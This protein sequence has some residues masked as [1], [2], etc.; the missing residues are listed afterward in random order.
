MFSYIKIKIANI[1]KTKIIKYFS[2]KFTEVNFGVKNFGMV[3]VLSG[4]WGDGSNFYYKDVCYCRTCSICWHCVCSMGSINSCK[5]LKSF[6]M[7]KKISFLNLLFSIILG[8]CLIFLFFDNESLILVS[9]IGIAISMIFLVI[10][11][12]FE[13][14]ENFIK[15]WLSHT[16]IINIWLITFCARIFL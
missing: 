13:Y 14:W 4:V 16:F 15:K 7:S 9:K 1:I 10:R 6:I 8:I 3:F 5:S 11:N 2:I 12:L